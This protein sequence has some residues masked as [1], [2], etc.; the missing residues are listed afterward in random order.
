MDT[1]LTEDEIAYAGI[2]GQRALLRA[3]RL[4]AVELLELLLAAPPGSTRTWAATGRC[5]PAP[6]SRPGPPT[7]PSPPGT[8]GRCWGSPSR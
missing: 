2:D 3:G 4:T 5:S 6:T 1:T 8:T 7:W